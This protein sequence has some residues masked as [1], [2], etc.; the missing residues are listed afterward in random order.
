MKEGRGFRFAFK[1]EPQKLNRLL[2]SGLQ[3]ARPVLRV[4]ALWQLA[5]GRQA[6]RQLAVNIGLIPKMSS[7]SSQNHFVVNPHVAPGQPRAPGLSTNCTSTFHLSASSCAPA[8]GQWN[9]SLVSGLALS[10]SL[11]RAPLVGALFCGS[12]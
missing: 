5:A 1:Q 8:W 10:G 9:A 6:I 2:S 12:I 11:C 4:L 7:Q 3:P